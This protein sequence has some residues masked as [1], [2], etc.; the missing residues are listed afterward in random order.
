MLNIEIRLLYTTCFKPI[1]NTENDF[2][3]TISPK[4][5]SYYNTKK[6]L[7]VFAYGNDCIQGLSIADLLF[8]KGPDAKDY[9]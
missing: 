5:K 6:Y 7:Q 4:K 1:G 8:N 3:Y 2:R 9:L